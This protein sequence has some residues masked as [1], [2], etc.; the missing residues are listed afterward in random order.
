MALIENELKIV[1]LEDL[2]N[3]ELALPSY[4]R[5]Y[6]WT[7]KSAN[8]LF[9]D[10]Y[11][12][13]NLALKEYRIGSV[14]LHKHK[15]IY[16]IVDGQ[17]R[18]ITV[19]ILL[20]ALGD[21]RS[22]LLKEEINLAFKEPILQNFF[23][24]KRRIIELNTNER[25][26]IFK[27]YLLKNCTIVKIVTDSEQEA[28]QFF[29][30]QNS[31][32]KELSP[33]DLLK[34]FHLREMNEESEEYKVSIIKKWEATNSDHLEDLFKNYLYP[35]TQWY[36]GNGGLGY[37]SSR[38]DAFKGIIGVNRE[39]YAVY[40]KASNLYVE[41]F[42]ATGG[43]ELIGSM[44]LNQFQLTQP[45]L[46]GKRFFK[47]V[48]HY[49]SL[50]E[51]IQKEIKRFHPPDDIPTNGRGETYIKQL[52]ESVLLFFVDRFGFENLNE[53]ILLQ[54]YSWSYSLR[55]VMYSVYPETI[56][57]YAKGEHDRLNYGLNLFT[58]ISE[59]KEPSE[60]K[61]L[62]FDKPLVKEEIKTKYDHLIKVLNNI[63][64]WDI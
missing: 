10:I 1:S 63:N 11:E 45:V 49:G 55:L 56:N 14:I 54:L 12:S 46:A 13:F 36:K 8:T 60:L 23:I 53:S 35:M 48:L 6:R 50:L 42:N 18:I 21:D 26:E 28:F 61:L 64:M 4:Q 25:K 5:P 43:N 29:D 2:M 59:M 39:N 38:I 57:K 32:G 24:L 40:H 33:H 19:S 16:Y 27:N 17:Q 20:H 58:I 3:L 47:Y 7:V 51:L 22:K 31:R 44:S 30:S 15:S 41:Q 9:Q 52:Y 37:S 62:I 34:S